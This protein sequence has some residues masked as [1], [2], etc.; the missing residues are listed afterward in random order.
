M[1]APTKPTTK[2]DKKKRFQRTTE[3][4]YRWVSFTHE[5][6]GD[7]QFELPAMSQ[8]NLGLIESLNNGDMGQLAKWLKDLHVDD[9]MVDAIRSLDQEEFSEFQK[10][11]AEGVSIPKS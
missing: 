2:A 10:D 1:S 5:L 4:Q 3:K 6:F 7:E 11:W 9:D 8:L